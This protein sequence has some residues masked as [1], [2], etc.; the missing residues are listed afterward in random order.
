[1][2]F[3]CFVR[4]GSTPPYPAL[5][6][7]VVRI[8]HTILMVLRLARIMDCT[9]EWRSCCVLYTVRHALARLVS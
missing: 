8:R 3:S 2:D 7:G 9:A 4:T 1:M 6:P 5:G